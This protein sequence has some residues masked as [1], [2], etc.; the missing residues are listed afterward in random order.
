MLEDPVAMWARLEPVV[1]KGGNETPPKL[2]LS[3]AAWLRETPP[4]RAGTDTFIL[5]F[6]VN[7]EQVAG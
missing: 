7:L 4:L 1:G 3:F 5:D 2:A 6:G